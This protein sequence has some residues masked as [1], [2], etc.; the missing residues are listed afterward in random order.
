MAHQR[1]LARLEVV[2]PT[3]SSALKGGQALLARLGSQARTT[4]DADATWRAALDHFGDVL[5]AALAMDLGDGFRFEPGAAR[6]MTAET[7]ERGLG[8]AI[9][10]LLDGREVE[11]IQLDVNAVLDDQRCRH[12]PPPGSPRGSPTYA[13]TTS[14]GPTSTQQTRQSCRSGGRY[15]RTRRELDLLTGIP[16]AGL[17]PRHPRNVGV[18]PGHGSG[19]A[20]R[21]SPHVGLDTP[22]G[23]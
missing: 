22:P 20:P 13:T 4:K 17:G 21:L 11:R 3:G 1:L 10:G 15:S 9:L 19:A 8:Y 12:H 2:A 14:P 18:G 6:P 5:E 16:T 23:R 7:D